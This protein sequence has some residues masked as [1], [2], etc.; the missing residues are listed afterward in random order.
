[1]GRVNRHSPVL[2]I[3]RKPGLTGVVGKARTPVGILGGAYSWIDFLVISS[4]HQCVILS[5]SYFLISHSKVVKFLRLSRIPLALNLL[6]S[7][8]TE[9]LEERC[10][11]DTKNGCE[12]EGVGTEIQ[13]RGRRRQK[14]NRV[15]S[16]TWPASMQ[17]Y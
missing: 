11:D 14:K 15:F 7:P 17:I 16:L 12:H 8:A 13:R 2:C 9:E 5:L 3:P 1:M 10:A 4:L 6:V